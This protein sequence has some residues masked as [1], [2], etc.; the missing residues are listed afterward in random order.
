MILVSVII[1]TCNR[2][3]DIFK[4][5]IDSVLNQTYKEIEIIVVNDSSNDIRKKEIEELIKSNSYEVKYYSN[6]IQ[7][8]ANYSRNIGAD[9]STGDILS[10]LDDDDYWDE[11]RIEKVVNSF[12]KGAEIIYSDFYIVSEKIKRY[13]KRG[14]P[15]KE[16]QLKEMLANNY[17]GGF[18]NVSISKESFVKV[19]KLDEKMKALQD[20]ELFVRLLRQ[21]FEL[22][23]IPEPLSYYRISNISI[24]LNGEKKLQGLK[25][26]MDKHQELF[27]KYPQSKKLRLENELVYSAKN[28]WKKNVKC[29]KALLRGID[30]GIKVNWLI[31]KGKAKYIAIRYFNIQ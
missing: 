22:F 3:V 16:E 23:Y 12:K 4:Q 27:D 17:L 10:F 29:I 7:K 13:S 9:L 25:Q 6:E 11:T 14:L 24:S 1:T 18:S 20:Q 21:D 8:G 19:G 26:L 2:E 28:G 5:A 31:L 15:C 30:S